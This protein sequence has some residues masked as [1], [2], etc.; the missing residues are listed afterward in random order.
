MTDHNWVTLFTQR[1]DEYHPAFLDR[2]RV[3]GTIRSTVIEPY[4][5]MKPGWMGPEEPECAKK[6]E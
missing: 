6:H 4:W 1:E 5:Y 2:C 3:C